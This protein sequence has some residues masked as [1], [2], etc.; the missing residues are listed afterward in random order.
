MKR[1]SS[2]HVS[3]TGHADWSSGTETG[4]P[5]SVEK[6]QCLQVTGAGGFK[7]QDER[8]VELPAAESSAGKFLFPAARDVHRGMHRGPLALALASIA[9]QQTG[10]QA[11]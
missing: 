1:S 11:A 6:A 4:G 7:F 8:A 5:G 2:F 9:P 3:V 10:Q